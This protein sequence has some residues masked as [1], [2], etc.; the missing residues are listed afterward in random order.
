M[1]DKTGA[2]RPLR[3]G[4]GVILGGLAVGAILGTGVAAEPSA[5]ATEAAAPAGACAADVSETTAT[6]IREQFQT[7][8]TAGAVTPP[9]TDLTLIIC[10]TG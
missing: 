10:E 9:S 8:F 1:S 3:S 5:L 2:P 6:T 7:S 4:S